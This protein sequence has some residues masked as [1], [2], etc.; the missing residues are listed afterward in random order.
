MEYQLRTI[1][2][3]DV[4]Q[5]EPLYREL[6]RYH[7]EVSA[8]FGGSFPGVPIEDQ[9]RECSED[10]VGGKAE[11]AVIEGHDEVVALC[12]VDVVGDRGY[13]DELVVMP[14][15]RGR[16]LG[17]R[18]MDWADGVFRKRD[19]RQVELRVVVGNESARRFYERRG[20]LPSVLEM[21]RLQ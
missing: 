21:R 8:H 19:V 3:S 17:S 20:F 2:A 16:G 5:L 13:L 10:L 11:V 9:L 7:N 6:A 14:E 1:N 4:A 18:L 15:H 12:K